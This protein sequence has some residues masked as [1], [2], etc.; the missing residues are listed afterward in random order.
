MLVFIVCDGC[1]EYLV[2]G[3]KHVGHRGALGPMR[4]PRPGCTVPTR[5]RGPMRARAP[6]RACTR[7]VFYAKRRWA[8][9]R[10]YRRRTT[11]GPW[12]GLALRFGFGLGL[13]GPADY[14]PY[15][16]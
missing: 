8:G 11:V 15:G 14:Y 13:S 12:L 10:R 4:A 5:R 9:L 3:P 2:S 1:D 6:R 7:A 16:R